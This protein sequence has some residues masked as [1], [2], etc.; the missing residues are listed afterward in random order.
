MYSS[1]SSGEASSSKT[2]QQDEQGEE[3]SQGIRVEAIEPEPMQDIQEEQGESEG[4]PAPSVEILEQVEKIT[5]EDVLRSIKRYYDTKYLLV[6]KQL[7]MFDN[8]I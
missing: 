5:K 6:K 7:E 2:S 1:A 4:M 8:A 3:V